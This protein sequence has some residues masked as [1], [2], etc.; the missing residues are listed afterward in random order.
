VQPDQVRNIAVVLQ[1]DDYLF[2]E[3]YLP[4]IL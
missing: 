3:W 2:H 4:G 1:D